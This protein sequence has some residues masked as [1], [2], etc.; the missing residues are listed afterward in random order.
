[1]TSAMLNHV[2]DI[3]EYSSA[4]LVGHRNNVLDIMNVLYYCSAYSRCYAT[5]Q[6]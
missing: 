1:M 3:P 2:T 4:F 5:T 6:R